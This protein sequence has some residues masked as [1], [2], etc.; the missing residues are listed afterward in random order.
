MAE[1]T[2]EVAEGGANVEVE[3]SEYSYTLHKDLLCSSS[4]FFRLAFQARMKEGLSERYTYQRKPRKLRHL[5]PVA[6]YP[7]ITCQNL[8]RAPPRCI[9]P[10]GQIPSP[11]PAPAV[12]HPIYRAIWPSSG[13]ERWNPR[14]TP[15]TP[16]RTIHLPA[17]FVLR[18]S[19]QLSHFKEE[20]AG[21]VDTDA[22]TG[23][24]FCGGGWA[25][26]SQATVERRH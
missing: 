8:D 21:T 5:R 22:G 2:Q 20:E 15:H 3:V 12:L 18:R 6:V 25:R 26:D 7:T 23:R 24:I 14:T 1:G 9:L 4:E 19:L 17:S 10:R 13:A 16:T 11:R